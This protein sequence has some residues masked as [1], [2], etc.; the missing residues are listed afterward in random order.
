MP[1]LTSSS[2]AAS[3]AVAELT[4][5]AYERDVRACVQFLRGDGIAALTEIRTPDLRRFLAAEASHRP[6]PSSQ[7]RRAV[8][9][10][11]CEV[12]RA[13]YETVRTRVYI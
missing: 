6:A 12:S 2:T 13:K 11:K 4:C 3:S 8:S 10:A 7:A 5:K 9:R 1:C